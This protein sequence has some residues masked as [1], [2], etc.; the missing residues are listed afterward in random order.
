MRSD[1]RSTP[2][3]SGL[4]AA[5]SWRCPARRAWSRISDNPLWSIETWLLFSESAQADTVL[6]QDNVIAYFWSPDGSRLAY[7]APSRTEGALRWT[8]VNAADGERWP[9]VD[10]IPS[11]DQ[12]TMFQFFDQ[13]AYSHSLWSPDSRSLVFAGRLAD[14]TMAIL[15]RYDAVSQESHII[16][17]DTDPQP[18]RQIIAD[19]TLG[20][21]SPR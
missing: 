2:R 19:G 3:S 13:Y 9:L 17:V 18:L 1:F 4:L 8:V 15:A 12:L 20:F 6:I 5:S 21:W 11:R 10:F 7:V 14:E 16:V